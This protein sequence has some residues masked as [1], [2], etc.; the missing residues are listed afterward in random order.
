MAGSSLRLCALL[1]VLS[2]RLGGRF[3]K[4]VQ[5]LPNLDK[6]KRSESDWRSA[7]LNWPDWASATDGCYATMPSFTSPSTAYLSGIEPDP[8]FGEP[9]AAACVLCRVG[10]NGLPW[11]LR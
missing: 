5:S 11:L 9:T 4:A 7:S 2:T 3:K 8:Q 1:R 6:P 10:E